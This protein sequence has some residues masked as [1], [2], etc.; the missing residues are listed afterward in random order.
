MAN[1]NAT[2]ETSNFMNFISN[3]HRSSDVNSKF[4]IHYRCVF[5]ARVYLFP[6]ARTYMQEI[7]AVIQYTWID[8][9][10][11]M[12]DVW[13][14]SRFH[15]HICL[16]IHKSSEIYLILLMVHM[17]CTDFILILNDTIPFL[18]VPPLIVFIWLK[19]PAFD[20][21]MNRRFSF[22]HIILMFTCSLKAQCPVVIVGF[23]ICF[24]NRLNEQ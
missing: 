18:S 21:A 16:N 23:S 14:V 22:F 6:E 17:Q 12:Y 19:W 2:A 10:T 8:Q 5:V 11:Y 15:V 1:R 9:T 24:C 20:K 4:I 3:V 13:V 7:V